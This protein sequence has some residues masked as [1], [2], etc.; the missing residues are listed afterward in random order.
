[1]T[2][3]ALPFL[4]PAALLACGDDPAPGGN[5]GN[6]GDTPGADAVTYNLFLVEDGAT[7]STS[8]GTMAVEPNPSDDEETLVTLNIDEAVLPPD[9]DA[10]GYVVDITGDGFFCM[11]LA[12]PNNTRSEVICAAE[13]Y[14]E[15]GAEEV[16]I[17]GAD[18]EKAVVVW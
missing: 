8:A 2:R 14:T 16:A 12:I 10:G 15:D 7:S 18:N 11:S 6:G 9:T 13:D 17:V 4:L 1:M 3:F 5:G